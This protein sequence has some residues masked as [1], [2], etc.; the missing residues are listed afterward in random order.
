MKK[1]VHIEK[2]IYGRFEPDGMF[3][4][5]GDLPQDVYIARID[6]FE[7]TI[8]HTVDVNT[9]HPVEITVR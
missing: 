6:D 5:W 1:T 4:L 9:S 3:H 8:E 2:K 7:L